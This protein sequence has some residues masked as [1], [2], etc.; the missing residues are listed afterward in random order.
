M[1]PPVQKQQFCFRHSYIYSFFLQKDLNEFQI[2]LSLYYSLHKALVEI[3]EQKYFLFLDF[4]VDSFRVWCTNLPIH[5]S[6]MYERSLCTSFWVKGNMFNY[7]LP[8]IKNWVCFSKQTFFIMLKNC[9]SWLLLSC[10]CQRTQVLFHVNHRG[11]KC[12]Q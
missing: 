2:F 5:P 1:C 8:P 12:T 3:L 6:S 11:N 4:S 7:S 9:F 10:Y